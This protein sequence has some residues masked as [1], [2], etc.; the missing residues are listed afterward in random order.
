MY[1]SRIPDFVAS[2]YPSYTWYFSR[3]RKQVYLTFDDGP[4][5]EITPWVLSIL[6]KFK[7]LATFFVVG[8]NVSRYPEI[9]ERIVSEGHSIGNHTFN[10]IN[11]RKYSTETYLKNTSEAQLAIKEA[12]GQDTDLFRPPYGRM[13]WR[14]IRQIRKSH[15]IIMMDVVSGDFDTRRS[16]NQ[17]YQDIID[18][19]RE[20]GIILLHDSQKAWPR[21]EYALPKALAVLKNRGYQFGSISGSLLPHAKTR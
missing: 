18:T 17:C 11:G 16:K 21:L 7:A 9:A 5:P 3:D 20:G 14:Q 10:H 19:T 12:T 6:A 13:K 1:L 4:H 2:I 15:H 8:E